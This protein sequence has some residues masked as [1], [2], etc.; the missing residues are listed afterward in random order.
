MLKDKLAP[1]SL[2]MTI[3]LDITVPALRVPIT[4]SLIF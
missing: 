1:V 2:A 4:I 3:L